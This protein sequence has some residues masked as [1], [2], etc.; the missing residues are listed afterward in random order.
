MLQVPSVVLFVGAMCVL[1]GVIMFGIV[2]YDPTRP[3]SPI[4]VGLF[5]GLHRFVWALGT[6]VFVIIIT[7]GKLRKLQ[8]LK[9][10]LISQ[11]LE[12]QRI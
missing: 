2:F 11:A 3:Y 7:L 9:Y 4:E 5:A 1:F 10:R 12:G 6:S 8:F